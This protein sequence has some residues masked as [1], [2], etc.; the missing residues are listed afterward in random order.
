MKNNN[1]ILIYNFRTDE[2]SEPFKTILK[3]NNVAINS[4]G[5]VDFLNEDLVMIDESPKGRLLILEKNKKIF[6]FI[7]NDYED[8]NT[9]YLNWSRYLDE[10]NKNKFKNLNNLKS[11]CSIQ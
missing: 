6:E 3:K 1:N 8:K 4:E 11:K 7:N 2:V 10:G 5:L 9:Y